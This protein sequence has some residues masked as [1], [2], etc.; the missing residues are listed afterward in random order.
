MIIAS[1]PLQQIY[2][3]RP[4]SSQFLSR[5][6][7]REP[8]GHEWL[9][10]EPKRTLSDEFLSEH[11]EFSAYMEAANIGGGTVDAAELNY[12]LMLSHIKE[13]GDSLVIER[14]R[15][16]ELLD[17]VSMWPEPMRTMARAVYTLL[18]VKHGGR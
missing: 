10:E 4:V 18:G 13:L 14:M 5:M 8:A 16:I 2:A 6:P 17:W 15:I 11:A 9:H 7:D 1:E 3:G 12:L